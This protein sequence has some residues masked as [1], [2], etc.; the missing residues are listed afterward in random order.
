[1]Q[2]LRS[3]QLRNLI[4]TVSL[5]K[6][7]LLRAL[8]FGLYLHWINLMGH[9]KIHFN[10]FKYVTPIPWVSQLQKAFNLKAVSAMNIELSDFRVHVPNKFQITLPVVGGGKGVCN[11]P[12]TPLLPSLLQGYFGTHTCKHKRFSAKCKMRSHRK[13]LQANCIDNYFNRSPSNAYCLC[14]Y[15][16]F[17]TCCPVS[18]SFFLIFLSFFFVFFL[19]DFS[20]SR[21]NVRFRF[22]YAGA[23]RNFQL[24]SISIIFPSQTHTHTHT[25]AQ[26]LENLCNRTTTK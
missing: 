13:W 8:N 11:R 14:F 25:R 26:S 20:P 19:C 18:R 10:W 5:S 21:A 23:L 6:T 9:T 2:N 16:G 15:F 12:L 24:F 3:C 22:T 7:P 4:K 17:P 1:M